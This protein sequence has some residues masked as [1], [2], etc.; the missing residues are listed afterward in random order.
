MLYSVLRNV[1]RLLFGLLGLRSEGLDKL[2]INGPIIVACNH[3]SNWDPIAVGVVLNRPVYFMA[4]NQLFR[5]KLASWFLIRLHAFP[6]K[7]ERHAI[8][9]ALKVLREGNVLGIFPQGARDKSGRLK[10]QAGVA[11]IALKSGAPVVPIAC[12]G[13]GRNI[14]WG[15]S[16]PLLIRVGDPI[17]LNEYKGKKV[18]SVVMEQIS[19]G[20]MNK[21]NGLLDK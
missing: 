7:P 18:S 19:E 12:I 8:R 16:S 6:I 5:F 10:A 21:I 17:D 20:I 1:G 11:M 13:T 9:Q 14:P 3:V 2:P 15:W 4:K